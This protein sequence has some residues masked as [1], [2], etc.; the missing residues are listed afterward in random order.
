[1][2][3]ITSD[4]KL[5]CKRQGE[6]LLIEGWGKDSLRIRS[7]MNTEFTDRRW[8]L[9]EEPAVAKC[10]VKTYQV[11]E[12]TG[13]KVGD[14]T[15]SVSETD[16]LTILLT[17]AVE[18]LEAEA[19]DGVT[20]G[21]IIIAKIA[22]DD[23][24][25]QEKYVGMYKAILAAGKRAMSEGG[26]GT[27]IPSGTAIQNARGTFL[28]DSMN[29]DGYHLELTYGR[30]TAACAWYEALTGRDV[31]RNAWHPASI[32]P[33]TAAACRAAAHAACRKPYKVTPL[34]AYRQQ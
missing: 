9:T 28:G 5:V 33:E 24:E 8:A 27:V 20:N 16:T 29:R 3:F 4:N 15:S 14:F 30:Y 25:K 2:E 26:I 13:D 18:A 34:P 11:K 1:M 21:E 10:D 22:G 17:G 7:T 12:K 31:R 32:T 23:A 6:T 19:S